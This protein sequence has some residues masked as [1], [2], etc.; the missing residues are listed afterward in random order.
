MKEQRKSNLKKY[1]VLFNEKYL[2]YS[3]SDSNWEDE[4]R[5]VVAEIYAKDDTR[6]EELFDKWLRI[7]MM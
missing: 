4:E 2:V 7:R 1:Y 6:A 5:I 3:L